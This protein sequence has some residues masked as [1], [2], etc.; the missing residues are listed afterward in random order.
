MAFR[1]ETT[2]E[3]EQDANAILEWLL[4]QQAGEHGL[5]WFQG[6]KDAIATLSTFPRRCSLARENAS[7]SFEMRQLFYGRRPHV[8][9]ILFT[10]EDEVVYVLRIRH[11]RRQNLGETH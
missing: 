10:I 5:R 1:V 11:G 4:A 9:R 3:A 7:V 6:L 2:P 8:Y